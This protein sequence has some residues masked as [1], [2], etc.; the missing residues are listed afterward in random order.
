MCNFGIVGGFDRSWLHLLP[1]VASTSPRAR[2]LIRAAPPGSQGGLFRHTDVCFF[3]QVV[4][5]TSCAVHKYSMCVDL[6]FGSRGIRRV[7]GGILWVAGG[8]NAAVGCA[9]WTLPGKYGY[10]DA[11]RR[12]RY[13]QGYA[14]HLSG[15]RRAFV[16]SLAVFRAIACA[17]QGGGCETCFWRAD[18]G[19]NCL[20][21]S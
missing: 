14:H 20:A 4:D 13:L 7:I 11:L 19:E 12:R 15:S 8:V 17:L 9:Y 1:P 2:T 21:T 6:N 5:S 10:E 16:G 18:C 3:N